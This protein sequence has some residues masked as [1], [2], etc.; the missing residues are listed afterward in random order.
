MHPEKLIKVVSVGTGRSGELIQ[1]S[2]LVGESHAQLRN[3][4]KSDVGNKPSYSSQ[5]HNV[6]DGMGGWGT[7]RDR[8]SVVRYRQEF[9]SSRMRE[10]A[11]L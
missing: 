2:H 3:E 7:R 5:H 9:Y 6:R 4:M 10:S 1:P 11:V 8:V